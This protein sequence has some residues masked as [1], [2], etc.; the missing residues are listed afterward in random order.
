MWAN[1]APQNPWGTLSSLPG[2]PWVFDERPCIRYGPR[3]S[4][5]Q[6]GPQG[7]QYKKQGS[8]GEWETSDKPFTRG[9][10]EENKNLPDI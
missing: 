3:P 2:G 6:L 7:T 5:S 1:S 8:G 10:P 9:Y 4:E